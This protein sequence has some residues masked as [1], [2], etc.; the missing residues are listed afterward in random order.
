MKISVLLNLSSCSK[1]ITSLL[2]KAIQTV[3]SLLRCLILSS[4]S[5]SIKS[6]K[7]N[8]LTKHDCC[9]VL[10]NGPSLKK[11]IDNGELPSEDCDYTCLNSFCDSEYF[12]QLK[13]RFY[14]L[15]DPLFFDPTI[16]RARKQVT[17]MIA[18]FEKVDWEMY[19]AIP[20]FVNARNIQQLL[21]NK[22]IKI[23]RYNVTR[24][25]GL[26]KTSF[27]LY[28]HNYGMPNCQTVLIF[29]IFSAINFKYKRIFLYG[30]D[31]TWLRDLW[32]NDDNVLCQGDFHVYDTNGTVIK[33]PQSTM[34]DQCQM[35]ANVFKA[36][37]I[38][39]E[40]ADY[41]GVEIINATKGS[42]IDAYERYKYN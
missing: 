17:N 13:P 35:T 23:L 36:H 42:F 26:K 28:K 22:N 2:S 27:W 12:Y 25:E 24:V 3:G 5:V 9:C 33:L 30:A 1:N 4:L 15:V 34:A 39:R 29:S 21:S 37:E 10:A 41:C 7:Y 40:Y 32:V 31:Q 11:A 20:S 19:L 8:L 38:L 14:Y 6:K 16:E 18:A